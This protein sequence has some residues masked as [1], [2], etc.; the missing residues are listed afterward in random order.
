MPIGNQL[1]LSGSGFG[2]NYRASCRARS[3]AE[4]IAKIGVVEEEADESAF[5][6]ELVFE[7]KMLPESRVNSLVREAKELTAIMAASA[8][9]NR[10]SAIGNRQSAIGN[11]QSAINSAS[12]PAHP[13][14]RTRRW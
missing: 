13:D 4:F 2:S 3:P 9:G 12:P 8:I 7:R 10:Q 6:M 5:W 1:V 11:R 14:T